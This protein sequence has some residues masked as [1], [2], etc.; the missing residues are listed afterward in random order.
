MQFANAGQRPH[1]FNHAQGV[2]A[3][4]NN[5]SDVVAIKLCCHGG[6][7][8]KPGHRVLQRV[9]HP[10]AARQQVGIEHFLVFGPNRLRHHHTALAC[11]RAHHPAGFGQ[12][13]GSVVHRAIHTF[14]SEQFANKGLKFKQ[15]LQQPLAHFRLVGSVGS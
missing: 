13:G 12:R 2:G 3:L 11:G 14:A 7:I 4:Q 5:A 10:H 15:G 6:N 8:H 1:V 9:V